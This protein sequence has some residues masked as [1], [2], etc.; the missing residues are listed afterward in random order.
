MLHTGHLLGQSETTPGH[1][2]HKYSLSGD[3]DSS[4]VCECRVTF[5]QRFPKRFQVPTTA[6]ATP[7]TMR[8]RKRTCSTR[9]APTKCPLAAELSRATLSRAALSQAE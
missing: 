9:R 7:R 3:T 2:G 4:G 5:D 1:I 6:S 8:K